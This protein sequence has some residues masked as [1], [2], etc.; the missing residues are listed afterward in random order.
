MYRYASLSWR[1]EWCGSSDFNRMSAGF[2]DHILTAMRTPLI[3][4]Q[5]PSLFNMYRDRIRDHLNAIDAA[6]FP[7][8][9]GNIV[10]VSDI[11]VRM[12]R[13]NGDP[14]LV[15][16]EYSCDDPSHRPLIKGDSLTFI[17]IQ[18]TLSAVDLAPSTGNPPTLQQW[19]SSYLLRLRAER[20]LCRTCRKLYS[21]SSLTFTPL[22]WVWIDISPQSNGLSTLSTTL[23]IKQDFKPDIDYTLTGI[24]YGGQNHFSA[25]WRDNSGR[26]WVHDGMVDSGRPS[27]DAVTN[28]VQLTRL[29]LRVMHILIYRL[30]SADSAIITSST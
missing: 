22:P 1:Q 24:I 26:W 30:I 9:G 11:F 10:A 20:P 13:F 18:H 8:F 5:L 16:V 4:R 14:R 21:H 17:L 6:N 23:A 15:S 3:R 29:G 2:F 28:D 27:L 19:I 12:C 7:R 25:R